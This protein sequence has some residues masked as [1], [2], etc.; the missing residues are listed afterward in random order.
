[1]TLS[2]CYLWMSGSVLVA[3]LGVMPCDFIQA[4]GAY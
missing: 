2:M 4:D 1:M 3:F